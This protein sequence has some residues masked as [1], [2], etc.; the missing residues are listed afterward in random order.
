MHVGE[1][2][3]HQEMHKTPKLH[4]VVLQRGTCDQESAL[5]VEPQECLPSL[6][7]EVLDILGLIKDHVVPLFPPECKVILDH[8]LVR[9]NADVK[10]V[11]FAPT[12]SLDLSLLLGTE[13]GENLETWAP[14]FEFHFP[15]H[16]DGCRHH[17]QVRAPDTLVTGQRRQ[18]RDSLNSLTKS[19]LISQN[20][21]KFSVM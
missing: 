19:H 10:R 16:D 14:L 17:D 2:V 12:M 5:G 1:D 4:H 6:G 13:V 7:L 11:L 8:K 21:V 20:T 15:V 9:S 3:G 18:H